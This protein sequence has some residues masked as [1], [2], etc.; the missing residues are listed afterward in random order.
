VIQF[1]DQEF[2][3]TLSEWARSICI[4]NKSLI[5]SVYQPSIS[6]KSIIQ[7]KIDA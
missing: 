1:I 5:D 2:L 4:S 3:T 7:L 6:D